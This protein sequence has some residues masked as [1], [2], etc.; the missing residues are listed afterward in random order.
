MTWVPSKLF[1]VLLQGVF[2]NFHRLHKANVWNSHSQWK[3]QKSFQFLY[4]SLWVMNLV[5]KRI[6]SMDPQTTLTSPP[7]CS[8]RGY[9]FREKYFLI[10]WAKTWGDRKSADEKVSEWVSS[11]HLLPN[12]VN[13]SYLL[14]R[15]TVKCPWYSLFPRGQNIVLCSVHSVPI[16]QL[17][18]KTQM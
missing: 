4:C 14:G 10:A 5:S 17:I 12:H 16:D 18:M 2:G 15:V 1:E 9:F 13:L 7:T 3:S 11:F 8:L 6:L